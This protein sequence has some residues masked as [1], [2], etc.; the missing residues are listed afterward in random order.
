MLGLEE[1]RS[2]GA[3]GLGS[4]RRWSLVSFWEMKVLRSGA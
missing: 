1:F 4:L 2:S 3:Y